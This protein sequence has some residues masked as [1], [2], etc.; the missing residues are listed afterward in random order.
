MSEPIAPKISKWPFFAADLILLAVGG[1]IF[2]R[3]HNP[4]QPFELAGVITCAVV[5][6][7]C[8][9]KPF[10]QEYDAVVKFAESGSLTD[11]VQQIQNV[12]QIAAEITSAQNFLQTIQ[13]ENEKVA[14]AAKEIGD[15][16]TIEAKNFAEFMKTANDSEKGHLRLEAEKLRRAEGE[17]VQVVV[18]ML[19]NTF[20]L[21]HA[22][23]LTGQQN[24]ITQIGQFQFALRDAARRVGLLAFGAE[25]G[26]AF[27]AQK[28]HP[29][30][31]K[32]PEG[33]ATVEGTSGPGYTFQGRL[34]RPAM[35][36]L[37][38]P[39]TEAPVLEQVAPAETTTTSTQT[40]E[41]AAGDQE[42]RLL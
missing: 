24:L 37:V 27:D 11:T 32:L 9:I 17:W 22:A 26:E 35:V 31:G 13:K 40:A 21:H 20:A 38:T 1:L 3:G 5:G 28:H 41:P 19:D 6:A 14:V 25:A 42:P 15:R 39:K 18:R 2:Q 30:D 33:P 8:F 7:W 29:A 4:L 12:E 10:T 36:V 16:M 34:V 23:L